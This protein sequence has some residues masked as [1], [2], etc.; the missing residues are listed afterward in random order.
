MKKAWRILIVSALVP[1]SACSYDLLEIQHEKTE[2]AVVA[3]GGS[4]DSVE[5]VLNDPVD[6]M[7]AGGRTM[8]VYLYNQ[9]P[10]RETDIFVY[11]EA[12]KLNLGINDDLDRVL[13]WLIGIPGEIRA[14]WD[15]IRE[16]SALIEV[17]YDASNRVTEVRDLG[18]CGENCPDL[19]PSL[20]GEIRGY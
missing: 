12:G 17:R 10:T 6:V 5:A 1:L 19:E 9:G 4:R 14:R 7:V 2:L 3:P 18:L 8:A 15:H 20:L 13:D 11:D 16:R